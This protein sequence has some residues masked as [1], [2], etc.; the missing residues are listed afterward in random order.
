MSIVISEEP[1]SLCL[2][3]MKPIFDSHWQE[4][5]LYK[6]HIKLNP[7]Y[8]KYLFMAENGLLSVYTARNEGEIIG[9]AVFFISPHLHYKDHV[10]AN[11]D[12]VYIAKEFRK[13]G[14]A[15]K[16]FTY[17][18]KEL[19]ANYKVDVVSVSMKNAFPFY[20][21]MEYLG[22]ECIETIYSKFIGEK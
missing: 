22:F 20:D 8:E 17:A 11:N 13:S 7:D 2:D 19:K 16:L 5:A 1:L 21:L 9:Y 4:I 3:E 15:V 14:L 6:N 12:I 18:E 10:Y